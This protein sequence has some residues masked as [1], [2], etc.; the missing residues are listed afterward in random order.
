MYT[1]GSRTSHWI[2]YAMHHAESRFVG[3]KPCKCS[4]TSAGVQKFSLIFKI[5]KKT[6]TTLVSI[7]WWMDKAQCGLCIHK[8]SQKKEWSTD[9]CI[10]MDEPRKRFAELKKLDLKTAILSSRIGKSMDRKQISSFQWVEEGENW[11]WLIGTGFLYGVMKM[12][13]N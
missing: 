11:E 3:R 12:F 6:K 2:M 4:S 7:N 10:D 5:A 8:F 1:Q 9:T 13:W